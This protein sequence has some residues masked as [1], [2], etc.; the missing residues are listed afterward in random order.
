MS[1][2]DVRRAMELFK[3]LEEKADQIRNPGG[4]LRTSV[5]NEFGGSASWSAYAPAGDDGWNSAGGNDG[6]NWKDAGYDDNY[7]K[8]NKR[9]RWLNHNVFTERPIDS[10]AIAAMAELDVRRAMDLFKELE[11]K[12]DQI[13]NPG[14]YLK[15]AV[16]REDHGKGPKW[17]GK[18]TT[19]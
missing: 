15:A 2:L 11:D 16:G 4:Y 12:A 10:S 6:Y 3:D 1:E 8:I 7:E 13:R 14:G 9:A 17:T 5:K 18:S 19:S